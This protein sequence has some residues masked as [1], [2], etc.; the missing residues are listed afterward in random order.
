MEPV[1]GLDITAETVGLATEVACLKDSCQVD[2]ASALIRHYVGLQNLP[3]ERR[4]SFGALINKNPE[5][6]VKAAGDAALVEGGISTSDWLDVAILKARNLEGVRKE[7]ERNIPDWLSYYSLSPDRLMYTSIR[8]ESAEK[9]QAERQKVT[10]SLEEKLQGLT[11][12]ERTYI[13]KNLVRRDEGDLDRLHRL[14]FFLLAGLPLEPFAGSLFSFTF[15]TSLTPTIHAPRREFEHLIRF[16]YLDWDATRAAL[17]KRIGNLGQTRSSVGDW[18]VV[19]ALRVTGDQSDAAEAEQLAEL[20]TKDRDRLSAWRLIENYCATDPCDPD[21]LRPDNIG[22]TAEQYRNIPVDQVFLTRSNSHEALF[23]DMAMPGVARF[24]PEAGPEAI[25]RLADH[26]LTRQGL[27]R[28]QALL[29]LLPTS[30][31]MERPV[32]DALVTSAQSS[33]DDPAG[34][35]GDH[36]DEWFTAQLLLFTAIPHLSGDEQL[37]AIN[38]IRTNSILLNLIDSLKPASST[39]VEALLEDA[40]A[41]MDTHRLIRLLRAINH[42]ESPLTPRSTNI[43]ADLLAFPDKGIRTEA[44][45]IASSSENELLLKRLAESDWDAGRL[46]AEDDHF[47][48]W[49]GS[50]ALMAAVSAGILELAQALE[51]MALSHYGFAADRLGTTAASLVTGRV[52]VAIEKVLN[53]GALTALPEI[54]QTIPDSTSTLPPSILVREEPPPGD[55]WAAFARLAETDEQLQ[56]RQRRLRQAYQ[57]FSKHLT[58]ADAHLIA[59][60]LTATGMA[61]IVAARPD[62]I[63]VWHAFLLQA[64]EAQKR[65][66]HLFAMQ[67]AGAIARDYA[68]LAVA[69][70]RAYS[71]VTPLVRHVVG[72]A[73]VPNEAEVLW[74]HANVPQIAAECSKQLEDCTSDREIAIEVL[75]AFKHGQECILAAYVEQLLA[76][77]EPVH[78]ARALTVAGFSDESEFAA[79]A[80]SRFK[81]TKGFVGEAYRAASAAYDRNR[82]SRH[83]YGLLR[84]ATTPL[85][86]WRYSVLLSKIVDGRFDLWGSVRPNEG[87]FD[88]FF[89]TIEGELKQR[90]KKWD[91]KRKDKLFGNNVPH[92]VFLVRDF[93]ID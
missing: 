5:A 36:D 63:N 19:N 77:G 47:E 85:D 56:E 65:S 60:D 30:V 24:E 13:E 26:M 90:I 3:Q 92:V 20:L 25:R 9:T 17:A 68:D 28:H 61:A 46:T 79:H 41:E 59:T 89:P 82:W 84:S 6:F 45:G 76:T 8:S 93:S 72:M 70:F 88:A 54:E 29:A 73:K 44:L 34:H 7:L 51:R 31:L 11:D 78:I 83:W 15:S 52:H 43:I 32:V 39:V 53:L 62:I 57:R 1:S 71:T 48:L 4:E 75:A 16:N 74:S 12:A 10:N 86:F 49:Y 18:A 38:G 64:G 80:L 81:E 55:P 66:L 69:V 87:L 91:E 27:A 14:A 67:F 50:A 21:T 23:F 42:A 40:F 35:P 33:T 58:N 2:V 22:N 37:R